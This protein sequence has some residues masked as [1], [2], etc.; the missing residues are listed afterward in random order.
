MEHQLRLH[1]VDLL[2]TG[3]AGHGALEVCTGH[4]C[5]IE[6][7]D[8]SGSCTAPAPIRPACSPRHTHT[9]TAAQV[10]PRGENRLQK[11]AAGDLHGVV[12]VFSI[13]RGAV[14]LSFKTPPCPH[15]VCVLLLASLL[16]HAEAH[17]QC[18][19]CSHTSWRRLIYTIAG[20]AVCRSRH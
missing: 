10:L 5:L 4:K 19:Y 8:A 20:S 3:P 13:K 11:V 16:G 1:C 15:K 6:R 2:Q 12:Q 7:L 17:A 14:V 18:C 9:A